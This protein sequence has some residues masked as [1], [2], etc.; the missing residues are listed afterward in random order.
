MKNLKIVSKV[1]DDNCYER[2]IDFYN[3]ETINNKIINLIIINNIK[4][5]SFL[6]IV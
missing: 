1:E 5:K 2:N 3:K 4:P 6:Q